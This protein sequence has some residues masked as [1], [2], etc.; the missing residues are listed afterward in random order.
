M[1][2]VEEGERVSCGSII[3]LH[4]VFGKTQRNC[5]SSQKTKKIVVG[6]FVGAGIGVIQSNVKFPAFVAGF[7]ITY[8]IFEF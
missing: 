7:G 1:K 8:K 3:V 5:G 4:L 2:G 6:P